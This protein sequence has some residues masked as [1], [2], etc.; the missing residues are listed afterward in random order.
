MDPPNKLSE[1]LDELHSYILQ[2]CIFVS[3]LLLL[4]ILSTIYMYGPRHDLYEKKW[5]ELERRWE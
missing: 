2:L 3:I 1:H 5:W 4:D